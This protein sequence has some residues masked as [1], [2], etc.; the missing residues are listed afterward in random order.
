MA[1]QQMRRRRLPFVQRRLAIQAQAHLAE[2]FDAGVR[3]IGFKDVG[4]PFAALH[5]IAAT[6]R[7][8]G[9]TLYLEVVSLDEASEVSARHPDRR[10]R[11]L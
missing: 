3:H 10:V 4:L 1:D 11:H 7:A 2:V 9:R 5:D 8:A 6:V